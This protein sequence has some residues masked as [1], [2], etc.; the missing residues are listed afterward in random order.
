[1]EV[2]RVH[3]PSEAHA[4]RLAASLDGRGHALRGADARWSPECRCDKASHNGRAEQ[5][6]AMMC[7]DRNGRRC[8]GPEETGTLRTC[9]SKFSLCVPLLVDN[10]GARSTLRGSRGPS[11]PDGF[12]LVAVVASDDARPAPF[13]SGAT[14][15]PVRPRTAASFVGLWPTT[16]AR[17]PSGSASSTGRGAASSRSESYATSAG[18]ASRNPRARHFPPAGRPRQRS[19]ACERRPGSATTPPGTCWPSAAR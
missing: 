3:S 2:I 6:A 17:S 10:R 18:S 7:S 15:S 4:L 5:R 19:S 1:M 16:R 9:F 13:E 12:D 8:Q 11:L 14:I